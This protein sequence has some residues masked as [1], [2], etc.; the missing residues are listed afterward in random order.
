MRRAGQE[1]LLDG[2]FGEI[3]PLEYAEIG[4]SGNLFTGRK[5]GR[6]TYWYRLGHRLIETPLDEVQNS[7]WPTGM[8]PGRTAGRWG[9]Y[10]RD[11]R[12]ILPPVYDQIMPVA[13]P[14]IMAL[15]RQAGLVRVIGANMTAVDSFACD[16]L[17]RHTGPFVQG[18]RR[19]QPFLRNI[20]TGDEWT[21][22]L[23]EL[24]WLPDAA[25]LLVKTAGGVRC[26]DER[27]TPVPPFELDDFPQA[28]GMNARF[29]GAKNGRNGMFI[30]GGQEILPFEYDAIGYFDDCLYVS[31]LW[32]TKDGKCG[33]YDLLSAK[34]FPA[35]YDDIRPLEGRFLLAGAEGAFA[36]FSPDYEKLTAFDLEFA[37][38]LG[39]SLFLAQKGG[40][41]GLLDT[42]GRAVLPFEYDEIRFDRSVMR[43]LLPAQKSGKWGF[44]DLSGNEVIPFQYEE[45]WNVDALDQPGVW[46]GRVLEDGKIW[47]I[48]RQGRKVREE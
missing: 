45:A 17:L 25:F 44:V 5:N 2:R 22:S 35:Q 26:Y 19:G 42:L 6:T 34:L 21:G 15:A 3:V 29:V 43:D 20:A 37:E 41:Y 1:G 28:C 36:L 31:R 39:Q 12:A 9:L 33:F 32:L 27:F 13:Q 47:I 23:E 4:F 40:R 7:Y 14:G 8:L 38:P 18:I 10:R 48:D 11:L 46:T 30:L 24:R 16:S